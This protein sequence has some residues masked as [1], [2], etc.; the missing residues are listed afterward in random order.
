[1]SVRDGFRELAHSRSIEVFDIAESGKDDFLSRL[2]SFDRVVVAGGDGSV[3]SLLPF[4][5][6][7]RSVVG[8]IPLGTGNDLA[9]ELG[10][11]SLGLSFS[12]VEWLDFFERAKIEEYRVWKLSF[13]AIKREHLFVNYASFGEDSGIIRNFEK[14]RASMRWVPKKLGR[15]GNRLLYLREGLR[16]CGSKALQELSVK[17][18]KSGVSEEHELHTVF[19]LFFSNI[20]SVMGLGT[21]H[22]RSDPT[23]FLLEVSVI[24]FWTGFLHFLFPG[25]PTVG[26]QGYDGRERWLIANLPRWCTYQTDGEYLGEVPAE[27]AVIEPSSTLLVC[28]HSV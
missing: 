28:S 8:I 23:D 25:I 17:G 27:V 19:S 2:S 12:L 3:S 15:F 7:H 18:E 21:A 22:P 14:A 24:R 9:R 5:V 6:E 11:L 16:A 26:Y 13:P 20:R 10:L 1:M 4:L